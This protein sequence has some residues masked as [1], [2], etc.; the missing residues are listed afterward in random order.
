MNAHRPSND[1][2]GGSD[3][4]SKRRSRRNPPRVKVSRQRLDNDGDKASY[5]EFLHFVRSPPGTTLDDVSRA[6]SKKDI[7]E[8]RANDGRTMMTGLDDLSSQLMAGLTI[9]SSADKAGARGNYERIMESKYE[10]DD[11]IPNLDELSF[12]NSGDSSDRGAPTL[13]EFHPFPARASASTTSPADVL[14]WTALGMLMGNGRSSAPLAPFS[15][16]AAKGAGVFENDAASMPSVEGAPEDDGDEAGAA[17]LSTDDEGPRRP[18]AQEIL[19]PEKEFAPCTQQAV[20]VAAPPPESMRK[21][22]GFIY[23]IK[24]EAR[25]RLSISGGG[26]RRRAR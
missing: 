13:A 6:L 4:P 19:L 1:A 20:F 5:A 9:K 2:M 7:G 10:D 26:R 3:P 24:S 15:S 17:V 16:S 21:P 8:P 11:E 12:C 25:Q 22:R 23:R 14:A 18:P